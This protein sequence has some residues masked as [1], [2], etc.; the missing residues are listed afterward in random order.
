MLAYIPTDLFR[1]NTLVSTFGFYQTFLGCTALTT[2]PT[3]LFRYN[4]VSSNFS[5]TFSGC[6]SL[7]INNIFYGAGEENSRFLNKAVDFSSCFERFSFTGIQ[8]VAP[9]LWNCDYGDS[10]VLDVA[11]AVDWAP[12]DIITGQ[13]SGAIRE[14]VS[15]TSPLIYRIKK[16]IE[17]FTLGEVVGVTGVPAKLADQGPANPTITGVSILASLCFGGPG[18]D[19]ASISNYADIPNNWENAPPPPPP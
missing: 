9:E 6:D 17:D 1:Y 4:I 12:G 13:S 8:G 3:D 15:K 2:I 7:C 16:K 19:I 5:G 10:I 18:N 14:I 11:P